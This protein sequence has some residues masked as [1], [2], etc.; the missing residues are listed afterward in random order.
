M[1]NLVEE[2]SRLCRECQA[3]CDGTMFSMVEVDA[4]ELSSHSRRRL[5][6]VDGPTQITQPCRHLDSSGCSAYQD[7]PARCRSYA[8]KQQRDHLENGGDLEARLKKV[9]AIRSIAARLRAFGGSH[10]EL[11]LQDP[12]SLPS[13]VSLDLVELAVRLQR[14]LGWRPHP[15][16]EPAA[17]MRPEPSADDPSEP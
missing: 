3:C 16:E 14:D 9:R 2:A 15:K 10:W 13:E 6:I 11:Q 5:N 4:D 12:R 7:R 8:C 1:A 17:P